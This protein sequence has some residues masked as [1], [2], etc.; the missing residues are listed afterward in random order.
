M[1]A[2][3]G[4]AARGRNAVRRVAAMREDIGAPMLGP[5]LARFDQS[6]AAVRLALG[7]EGYAAA[8][9]R[10]R[11]MPQADAIA[12]ARSDPADAQPG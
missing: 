9:Q 2:A 3:A 10:G 12:F 1:E 6:V 7:E 8:E 4:H 5:D 11:R